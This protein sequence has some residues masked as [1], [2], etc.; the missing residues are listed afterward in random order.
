MIRVFGHHI[1]LRAVLF[2]VFEL[3]M[4]VTFYNVFRAGAF[5][6][7]PGDT[8]SL[9]GQAYLL[10]LFCFIAFTTASACGLYNK[11]MCSDPHGIVMRLFT[12][13]VLMYFLMAVSISVAAV[14]FEQTPNL[15]LYYAIALGAVLAYFI[16]SLIFRHTV[17]AY[18][19]NGTAL[20]RRVLVIGVDECA[21]KIE[22][23]NG[24]S[25]SPYRAVGFV[26]LPNEA[27]SRRISSY[28]LLPGRLLEQPTGLVE[29]ARNLNA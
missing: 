26:P 5:H 17:F 10:P 11:E 12:V 22:Y 15:R 4:F 14:S 21:A 20:E 7:V 1:S 6:F 13:S 16:A 28:K 25:R 19:F 8:H 27:K 3:A 2:A 23:L 9:Y 29:Q 18:N 24:S